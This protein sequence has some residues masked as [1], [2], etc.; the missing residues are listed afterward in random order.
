MSSIS[1]CSND[2]AKIIRGLDH[3]KA[4]GHDMKSI[5]MLKICGESISKPLEIILKSCIEKGQFPS[6][7]KKAKMVKMVKMVKIVQNW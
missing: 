1:F 3:N 6:K 2:I 5:C 4:H 7:W